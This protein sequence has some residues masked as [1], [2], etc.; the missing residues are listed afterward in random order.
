MEQGRSTEFISMI[1]WIRTN[2]LSIENSLSVQPH[3]KV[4]KAAVL[5]N[6]ALS[7]ASA[8]AWVWRYILSPITPIPT[9][10]E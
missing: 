9:P 3:T 4:V 7:R 10:L 2:R 8:A 6:S 5:H 1:K